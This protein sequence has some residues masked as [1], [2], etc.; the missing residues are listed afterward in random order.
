MSQASVPGDEI[1]LPS[2]PE[3][4]D[5]DAPEIPELPEVPELAAP[6]ASLPQEAVQLPS[7]E[8][9]IK[10]YNFNGPIPETFRLKR[11]AEPKSLRG[12]SPESLL[13]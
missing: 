7:I 1:A 5:E 10:T 11:R 12:S 3:L 9:E 13:C 4:G 8:G 2:L 6:E